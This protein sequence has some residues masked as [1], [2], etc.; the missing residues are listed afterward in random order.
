MRLTVM[1]LKDSLVNRQQVSPNKHVAD[2]V[3]FGTI[4]ISSSIS[5]LKLLFLVEPNPGC[6][7]SETLTVSE[8]RT[9]LWTGPGVE[10]L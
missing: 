3:F 2:Q 10:P 1:P 4:S 9:G 6:N 5:V 8:H 7:P